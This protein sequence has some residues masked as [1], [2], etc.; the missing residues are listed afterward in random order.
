MEQIYEKR[1]A[2]LISLIKRLGHGGTA[3]IARGIGVDSSYLSRC[4]YPQGKPGKKNIGD[5]MVVKLNEKYPDWQS[6]AE[7]EAPNCSEP[8]APGYALTHS[9][10]DPLKL[11][12]AECELIRNFRVLTAESQ[13]QLNHYVSIRAEIERLSEPGST[14]RAQENRSSV[15]PGFKIDRVNE[16]LREN[17]GTATTQTINT[18]QG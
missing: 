9:A 13:D 11:S 17:F 10:Q 15:Q 6:D 18:G 2:N 3:K 5:E 4:T 8:T 7:G 1:R 16:T 12:I 14:Q